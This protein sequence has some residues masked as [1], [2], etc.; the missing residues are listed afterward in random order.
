M[1]AEGA[2]LRSLFCVRS[3]REAFSLAIVLAI[4]IASLPSRLAAA[5]D[6]NLQRVKGTVGYQTAE[7]APFTTISGRMLLPDD[8]LAI[9]RA[10]SAALLALPDSSIVGLGENTNVQ[11]GAFNQTADGPGSTITVNNGTLRFDVRRPAG[12]TANYR[13][14]TVTTQIA[15]RGT[16]GLLSFVNGNTTVACLQCAAD[17]VTVTVGTQTITLATGQVLTVSAAGAVVVGTVTAAL[18]GGFAGAGVSTSAATGAAAAT[19]GV[20]GASSAAA[21]TAG[22]VGGAVAAGAVTDAVIGSHA[23]PTPAPP[24]AAIS[25]TQTNRVPGSSQGEV[26]KRR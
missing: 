14:T 17:S 7:S 25:V 5:D 9:T 20:A 24:T 2:V 15:I 1:K 10:K 22:I 3:A 8:S 21:A 11:V 4:V 13:F 6:K 18:L 26:G 19:A 16:V 23:T 12:G